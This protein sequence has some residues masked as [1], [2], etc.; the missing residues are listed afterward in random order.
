[1]QRF[2]NGVCAT[3]IQA[4]SVGCTFRDVYIS[5]YSEILGQQACVGGEALHMV[6]FLLGI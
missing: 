4:L 1:M 2:S 6:A 3:E 5:F